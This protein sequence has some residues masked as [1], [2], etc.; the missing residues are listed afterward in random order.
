MNDYLAV[1]RNDEDDVAGVVF[2]SGRKGG[3]FACA[4]RDEEVGQIVPG[5]PRHG[6]ATFDAAAAEAKRMANVR[7]D[8]AAPRV[9]LLSAAR[10]A[11]QRYMQEGARAA[12]GASNPY[13]SGCAAAT[14][15]QRG[16]DGA[17]VPA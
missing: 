15:W 16:R 6:F 14:W 7:D 11:E 4:L 9:G 5:S 1:Y 8:V 10:Q 17:E 12:A 3:G 2:K 13:R